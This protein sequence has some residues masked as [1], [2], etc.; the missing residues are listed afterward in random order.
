MTSCR[1]FTVAFAEKKVM[2][3]PTWDKQMLPLPFSS[4]VLMCQEWTE[5]VPKRPSDEEAEA[6]RQSLEA[7][8]DDITDKADR[9]AGRTPDAIKS[10]G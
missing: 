7:C 10:L 1:V 8:L 6:L 9:A 2:K 5:A 3:L 4:G